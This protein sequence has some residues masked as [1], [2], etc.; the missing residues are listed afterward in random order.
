MAQVYISYSRKDIAFAHI[1]VE[2]LKSSDL[3]TWID[4]EDI[5]PSA[6]WLDEIF[7]A[8]EAADTFVYIVSRHSKNSEVRSKEVQHAIANQK[9]LIPIVIAA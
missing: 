2:A 6:D 3:E 9:R 7:R 8:I 1:L 4:W 5:P